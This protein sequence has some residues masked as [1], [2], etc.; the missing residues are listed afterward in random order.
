MQWPQAGQ[1]GTYWM[2]AYQI[3]F[4]TV[5]G[6]KIKFFTPVGAYRLKSVIL[7]NQ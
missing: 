2:S 1:G 6:S 4:L 7:L 3:H 5:E